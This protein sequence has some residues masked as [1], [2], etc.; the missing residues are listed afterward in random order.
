MRIMKKLGQVF[1]KRANIGLFLL[2]ISIIFILINFLVGYPSRLTS[3]T[4]SDNILRTGKIV[5]RNL[6]FSEFVYGKYLKKV[7]DFNEDLKRSFKNLEYDY[8]CN[9]GIPTNEVV[10][11]VE[12]K[13]E[14][15]FE[16]ND[17]FEYEKEMWD[18]EWSSSTSVWVNGPSTSEIKIFFF[19]FRYIAYDYTVTV[20]IHA[21]YPSAELRILDGVY[22]FAKTD[23]ELYIDVWGGDPIPFGCINCENTEP[24]VVR[25]R[26]K[27]DFDMNVHFIK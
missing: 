19:I 17:K 15:F 13:V 24:T 27:V 3:I 21:A 25:I 5:G 10:R 22:R 11:T 23:V 26:R 8:C 12:N 16:S 4:I 9:G 6:S 2:V 7:D 1:R 14:E 20:E 18:V